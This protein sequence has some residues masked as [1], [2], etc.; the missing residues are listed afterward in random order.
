MGAGFT[1]VSN[2]RMKRGFYQAKDGDP[3]TGRPLWVVIEP[4]NGCENEKFFYVKELENGKYHF[5]GE[6]HTFWCR[7]HKTEHLKELRAELEGL[8]IHY[9]FINDDGKVIKTEISN[10]PVGGL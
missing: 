3:K 9:Y 5:K 7:E 1:E 10:K 8:V 6:M 2:Y 4:F